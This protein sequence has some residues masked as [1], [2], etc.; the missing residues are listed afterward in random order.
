MLGESESLADA[1]FRLGCDPRT[2]AEFRP[3]D[4]EGSHLDHGC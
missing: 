4:V 2:S 3:Y 1:V